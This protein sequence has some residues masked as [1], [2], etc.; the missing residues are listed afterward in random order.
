LCGSDDFE[1]NEDLALTFATKA[2]MKRL[3]AGEFAMGY[4]KEL[5]IGA[6]GKKDLVQA[7]RWYES[8]SLL[9]KSTPRAID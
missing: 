8:V 9:L 2:A 7:K 1:K 6:G 5:G 3:P 4:Y